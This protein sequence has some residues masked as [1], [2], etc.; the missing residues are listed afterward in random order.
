V[1]PPFHKLIA[2]VDRLIAQVTVLTQQ[3]KD[4]ADVRY[5]AAFGIDSVG[6]QAVVNVDGAPSSPSSFVV[7]IEGAPRSSVASSA[8]L[9]AGAPA[10]SS[11]RSSSSRACLRGRDQQPDTS[12]S[13]SGP[14][15]ASFTVSDDDSSID[16]DTN[17]DASDIRNN[18]IS[19]TISGSIGADFGSDS[20]VHTGTDSGGT[21]PIPAPLPARCRTRKPRSSTKPGMVVGSLRVRLF[22]LQGARLQ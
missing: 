11:S 4:M 18:P 14:S 3:F 16:S 15:S 19:G 22:G 8:P 13:G 17:S 12:L 5:D 10:T 2:A 21:A 6:E 1:G 20:G 9:T 7:M